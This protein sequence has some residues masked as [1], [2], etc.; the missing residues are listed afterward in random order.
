MSQM[1]PR[2]I[3]H[4]LN[5]HII[6]QDDA[7]RS[8]AIALRNRWR[9]AQLDDEMRNEVTPKNILMIGPTGV[10]KTEIA[11]RL[12]RLA[13]APFVKVEATKFTE[14]GYVGK[15]VES[16]IRDL[17]ETA[18]KQVREQEIKKVDQRA[19]DSAEERILDVL[20]PPARS[21]DGQSEQTSSTRQVFRKKLREGALDDKEIEIEL[22]QNVTG[23]EIMTPPGME[24]MTSQLQNMFSSMG[25][26]KTV[27]RKLTVAEA[28]K[29]L[30]EEEAAKLINE[31]EI[32]AAAVNAA[33]QNGIVFLDEI[34]KVCRRGEASG[35]DVSRE[36]VQRD[37][38]PLIEGST[39]STKYG[40]IK[41]DHILFIAS[42]AFHLAKPSDLIPELQGRL[43]IRVELNSLKIND[44]ERILTEPKASLTRQYCELMATEGV[45]ITFTE[46]GVRRIAEI[47]FDVNE[48]TE[49]IGARR[50]H[51]I[52]ERLLEEISYDASDLGAKGETFSIDK[53]FVDK[54]LGE[55]AANEDLTRFIL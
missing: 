31:E 28:L 13:N 14:V 32:K 43:P 2:E 8:V 41:T 25:K 6:G 30:K 47:A 49:N 21:A 34:D 52:M 17:V 51:T 12:A 15:D 29:N 1:T 20:L 36:G 46:D 9:R 33:E 35:A 19:M 3:V 39:V 27:T 26:G 42:G 5:R 50:L 11:R 48:G 24:E 37:L 54:Q 45:E 55:L 53:A 44:F 22:S 40:M 7:K 23:V 10:G 4:E 38:L 16:I 18:V